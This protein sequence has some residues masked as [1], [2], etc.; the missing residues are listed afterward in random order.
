MFIQ[1]IG[2]LIGIL[3]FGMGIFY[4][5]KAANDP[6]SKKIYTITSVAGAI[7]AAVCAALLLI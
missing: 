5:T 6:D 4:R 7:L 3:V 2:L 1:I